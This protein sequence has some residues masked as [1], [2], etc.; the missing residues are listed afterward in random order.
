[1]KTRRPVG[2]DG[3]VAEHPYLDEAA[4]EAAPPV[5]EL[6]RSRG[7][8]VLAGVCRGL[9]RY[10]NIDPLVYR[11]TFALLTVAGGIG[12]ALY[13][14]AWLFIPGEY[15]AASRAERVLRRRIDPQVVFPLFLVIL[16]L[17]FVFAG[18]FERFVL[19]AVL[20]VG[21][22]TARARGVDVIASLRTLPARFQRRP[23][24][25]HQPKTRAYPHPPGP[26]PPGEPWWSVPT[27]Q[28][29]ATPPAPPPVP[30]RPPAPQAASGAVPPSE[31][32]RTRE[33]ALLTP[34]TLAAAVAVAGT[35]ALFGSVGV[36]SAPLPLILAAVLITV[37][38]GLALG[39][40]YGR[41]PT[42][43]LAGLAVS[44]A[45]VATTIDID[46]LRAE[47]GDVTWRPNSPG[48]MAA[49]FQLGAG[50]GNLLLT[51]LPSHRDTY[52]IRARVGAGALRVVIPRDATV[53]VDAYIGGGEVQ[54]PGRTQ[55]SPPR[56]KGGML[57]HT[58]YL[59][60]ATSDTASGSSG[61]GQGGG[62]DRQRISLTLR[63]GAGEAV[64]VRAPA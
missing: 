34:L 60:P 55:I 57:I 31:P 59:I 48:D 7:G 62:D 5:R 50:E 35:L 15:A 46:P 64:I 19:L 28:Q 1:M 61:R 9:G 38:L 11:V 25:H 24:P 27:E 45:L 42:L 22:L 26:Y 33:P 12:V 17:F 63:V 30:P 58:Q 8:R 13:V 23:P 16:G 47:F 52:D 51:D 20:L 49:P 21:V 44:V 53:R 2:D 43:V 10:T 56:T 29:T 18:L 3:W 14:L 32:R 6:R 54:V 37:G 39:T 4:A 36:I 40:W 41:G